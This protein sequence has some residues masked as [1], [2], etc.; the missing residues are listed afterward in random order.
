MKALQ[1]TGQTAFYVAY[2][3]L[4][5]VDVMNGLAA[6]LEQPD[7]LERLDRNLKRQNQE[8]LSKKVAN[9][10][11][12]EASLAKTDH[13]GLGRTPNFEARR[14]AAVPIYVAC[15]KT[16]LLF[17]PVR[18]APEDE[19]LPWMAA[20]DG[21]NETELQSGFSQKTLRQWMR[22]NTGH[23]S[24]SVVR[25]PATRAHRA[26]CE[27]ILNKG[28]KCYSEIRRT[29]RRVH[30]LPIPKDGPDASWSLEDHRTAFVAFL[31]FVKANLSDQ[32]A[33]RADAAWG[34]QAGILQ[35]MGNFALPDFVLREDEFEAYLPALAMQVGVAHEASLPT[36]QEDTPYTLAQIYDDEIE[37]L[38][39]DAYQ[40][41]YLIFGF[42]SW[43]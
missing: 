4:Q 20:L 28:P 33:V 13:F 40:R 19:V 21:V 39:A 2:E 41:D 18:S 37:A 15:A 14:G 3:D 7:K 10:E 26:F 9:F 36:P 42:G 17:L 8:P 5:D 32:T 38:V 23:R 11:E 29:L 22:T 1:T 16:P 24:F 30:K 31:G 25:H 35:G 34:S 6:Y 43:R 12:M 27:R